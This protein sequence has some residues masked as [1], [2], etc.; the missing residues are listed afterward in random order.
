MSIYDRIFCVVKEDSKLRDYHKVKKS[1]DKTIWYKIVL[2]PEY[3]GKED[4]LAIELFKDAIEYVALYENVCFVQGAWRNMEGWQDIKNQVLL[5]KREEENDV[6]NRNYKARSIFDMTFYGLLSKKGLIKEN[7]QIAIQKHRLTFLKEWTNEEF[8]VNVLEEFFG[9]SY[10]VKITNRK[11]QLE[12]IQ[13]FDANKY[14]DM[15]ECCW[16]H[17]SISSEIPKLVMECYVK[18]QSRKQ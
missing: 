18:W 10:V 12:Y 15:D 9:E 4:V 16:K 2:L 3:E 8:L 13:L 7:I 17:L 1:K 11:G 14:Y 5:L 6:S